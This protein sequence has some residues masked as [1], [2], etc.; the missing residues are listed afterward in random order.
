M[1][2]ELVVG[3]KGSDMYGSFGAAQ[4]HEDD[5]GRALRAAV[6]LQHAVKNGPGAMGDDVNLAARQGQGQIVA[7]SAEAGMGKSRLVA[8][9][10][11]LA[12]RNG[13]VGY[14]GA[15]Q[16]DALRTPYLAW[17][18]V[19]QAFFDIDP[20]SPVRRQ[21][22]AVEAT[23]QE[24]APEHVEALPLLDSV[25]DLGLADNDF[26]RTLA[27]Q[28]RKALPETVLV[29]CLVSAAREAVEDGG[30]L[31]RVLEDLHFIDPVSMELLERA[32]HAVQSLPVLML[33]SYRGRPMRTC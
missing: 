17:Q 27:P 5:A 25:L 7:I 9:G 15:C 14:G 12:R 24:H 18:R 3:D 2:L 10:I 29:K 11:G 28:N 8:E 16:P 13:F 4:V 32:A 21:L 20:A 30:G 26:T 31:L 6:A 33:L 22:R 19:W 1:L 23:L